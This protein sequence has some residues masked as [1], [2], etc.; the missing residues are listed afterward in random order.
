M[1]SVLYGKV[2]G[3]GETFGNF[4]VMTMDVPWNLVKD[5]I[6]GKPAKVV[7]TEGLEV[8]YLD[9][10]VKELPKVDTIVGIG[11]GQAV[12]TAK[13]FA[14]KRGCK[15]VFIPTIV[16]V[17]AYATPAAAVRFNGKVNYLGNVVPDKI[18]IDYPAIQSAPKRLNTAGTGDIYSCR[19]AL[20][21]WW[22]AHEKIDE[23]YDEKIAGESRQILS[24]LVGNAGEIRNVTDKGIKTLVQ[25]H[26]DTNTVQL[27]AKTPRPEEGSEHLFFYTLEELTKRAFVHGEVVGTGIYILTH[28]Q[29]KEEA[30][31]E[32][33]MDAM[34][35]LFRPK[36][37]G[38]THDEFI[39]TVL[40]MKRY[41]R[42][43]KSMF[44][45]VDVVEITRDDAEML[46]KKLA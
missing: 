17:N 19:T 7:M 41:S 29:N 20:F 2:D 27:E 33:E 44:T 30:I 39:D 36:D 23:F 5:R 9:R 4:A 12:D 35:L 10:L 45:I 24:T 43:A 21:D 1:T 32:R 46:W 26:I 11:G 14:W 37:Y 42:E 22:L 3:Q 13:Y 40:Q 16:S 34:G 25:L 8:E 6:G 38:I 18:I 15:A 31:V 28:F